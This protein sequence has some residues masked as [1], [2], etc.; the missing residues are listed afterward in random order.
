MI[1]HVALS[2]YAHQ[3]GRNKAE[4]P[5]CSEKDEFPA[6]ITQ[7]TIPRVKQSTKIVQYSFRDNMGCQ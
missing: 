4:M 3:S 5:V 7:L 1:N 2:E 6:L